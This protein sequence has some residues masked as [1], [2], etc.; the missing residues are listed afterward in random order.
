MIDGKSDDLAG[1]FAFK[2]LL[3]LIVIDGKSNDLALNFA[4]KIFFLLQPSCLHLLARFV[5]FWLAEPVPSLVVASL[6]MA[7]VSASTLISLRM[8]ATTDNKDLESCA[9]RVQAA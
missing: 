4:F 2:F 9:A 8:Q 1:V 3:L 5:L 7:L 6:F